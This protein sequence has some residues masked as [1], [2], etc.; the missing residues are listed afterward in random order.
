MFIV[1]GRY[2]LLIMCT[3]LPPSGTDCLGI[4]GTSTAWSLKGLLNLAAYTRNTIYVNPI[5]ICSFMFLVLGKVG[6]IFS[7]DNFFF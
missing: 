1:D 4:L 5:T 6:N 7:L 2:C 3:A